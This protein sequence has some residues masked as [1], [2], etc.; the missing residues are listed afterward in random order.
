MQIVHRWSLSLHGIKG[1][2]TQK[3]RS[4]WPLRLLDQLAELLAAPIVD[5]RLNCLPMGA[6]SGMC[7]QGR[8]PVTCAEDIHTRVQEFQHVLPG[9]PLPPASHTE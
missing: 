1:C 6:L 2:I 5:A 9:L 8:R 7:A 4:L 3:L